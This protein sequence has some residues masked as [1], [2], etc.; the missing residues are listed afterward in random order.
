MSLT[1]IPVS[2]LTRNDWPAEGGPA[3]NLKQAAAQ[4]PARSEKLAALRDT[5]IVFSMQLSFRVTMFLRH[6]NY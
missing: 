6:L 3:P 5:L 4:K 1:K 2:A